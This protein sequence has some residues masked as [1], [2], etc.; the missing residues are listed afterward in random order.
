MRVTCY[1]WFLLLGEVYKMNKNTVITVCEQWRSTDTI[2][3]L[4]N[5]SRQ[6]SIVFIKIEHNTGAA[7]FFQ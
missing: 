2:I 5:V 7:S 3:A 4:C 1:S 6:C